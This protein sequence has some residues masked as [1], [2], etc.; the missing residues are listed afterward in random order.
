MF[1]QQQTRLNG[2]VTIED[3]IALGGRFTELE[4]ELNDFL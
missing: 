4:G 3:K 2:T 1:R